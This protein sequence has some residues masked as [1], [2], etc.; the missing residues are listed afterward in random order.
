MPWRMNDQ[1]SKFRYALHWNWTMSKLFKHCLPLIFALE[2]PSQMM[3]QAFP[4]LPMNVQKRW[5]DVMF[6]FLYF[7]SGE[8]VFWYTLLVSFKTKKRKRNS[9][10]RW[11]S[12]STLRRPKYP[13]CTLLDCVSPQASVLRTALAEQL[14]ASYDWT[15]FCAAVCTSDFILQHRWLLRSAKQ[16][17]HYSSSLKR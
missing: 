5:R 2:A 6:L 14:A 15:A 17:P 11:R 10:I 1:L 16:P 4:I 9:N 7:I 3:K 12:C 13:R 8:T